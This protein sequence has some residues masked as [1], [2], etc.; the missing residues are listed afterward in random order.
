MPST[1]DLARDWRVAM[2][3]AAHALKTLADEGVVRGVS[4]SGTVVASTRARAH[5]PRDREAELTRERIVD[6]AIAIADT[7]GL[8]AL[9]LRGV[10]AKLDAPVMSLYRHVGNKSALVHLMTDAAIGEGKLPASA[11]AGWRAPLEIAARV[12]WRSFRKH[13]WLARV[14]SLTRPH[15]LPNAL[16]H[17]D[18]VLRALDGHGLDAA[19]RLRLHIV[20]HGFI[21]G[22]AVNLET[23]AEAVSE[24][25][26]SDEDW[27]RTQAADFATLAASGRYPA[28]AAVLGELKGGF[29]LDFE[30]VFELGLRALL[31]GFASVIGSAPRRRK[32]KPL[33]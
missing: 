16:A 1:R 14:I 8:P 4:R 19:A 33:R 17:A 22:M 20:L 6:A 15:P 25:G 7:E 10:A 31:D 12:Q 32:V 24:T 21:Q 9:S 23:E 3:T 11:A 18:W 5:R 2:A 28:F 13:P 26:M 30:I 29:E 27:M